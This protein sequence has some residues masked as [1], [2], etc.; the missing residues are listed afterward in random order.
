MAIA[1][2]KRIIRIGGSMAVIL[3]CHWAKRKVRPG[4]EVVIIGNDELRIFPIHEKN[5]QTKSEGKN[6]SVE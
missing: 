1:E 6:V 4:Q 2:I 5:E 3:P